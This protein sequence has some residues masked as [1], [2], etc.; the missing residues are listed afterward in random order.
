MKSRF[1]VAVAVAVAAAFSVSSAFASVDAPAAPPNLDPSVLPSAALPPDWLAP[2]APPVLQRIPRTLPPKPLALTRL[3]KLSKGAV[4][5]QRSLAAASLAAVSEPSH[6]TGGSWCG[7]KD[8]YTHAGW[9]FGMDTTTGADWSRVYWKP[10]WWENNRWR[11][12]D[13]WY[14]AWANDSTEYTGRTYDWWRFWPSEN[15]WEQVGKWGSSALWQ[16]AGYG[17]LGYG[18]IYA[19]HYFEWYDY[20]QPSITTKKF[21]WET[22]YSGPDVHPTV[23]ACNIP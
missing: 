9:S 19:G 12:A 11:T 7:N 13:V 17:G 10:Y 4:R 23:K 22:L 5:V 8:V 14:F 1:L 18:A 6:G 15:R 20:A 16:N 2:L 21:F 3:A